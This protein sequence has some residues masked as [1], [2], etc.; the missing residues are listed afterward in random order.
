[1]L[2]DQTV[3]TRREQRRRCF[4]ALALP[5]GALLRSSMLVGKAMGTE[6]RRSGSWSSEAHTVE[7]S[8]AGHGPEKGASGAVATNV[9]VQCRCHSAP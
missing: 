7:S 8:G 4:W 6:L 5:Q 1:M 9:Q 2:L 3:R